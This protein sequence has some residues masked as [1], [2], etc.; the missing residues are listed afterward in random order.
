MLAQIL[1]LQRYGNGTFGNE[2]FYSFG[3]NSRPYEV[4]VGDFN[5]DG[6]MDIAVANYGT[7]YVE[8]LLKL[9]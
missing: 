5:K 6:W 1:H 9:C 4:A 2:T 3:Y 8:I 7:D